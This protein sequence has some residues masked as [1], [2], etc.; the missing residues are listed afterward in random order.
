MLTKNEKKK[1]KKGCAE[2]GGFYQ[3]AFRNFS[4]KYNNF[5]KSYSDNFTYKRRG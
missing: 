5:L 4:L 3:A 2:L 1:K